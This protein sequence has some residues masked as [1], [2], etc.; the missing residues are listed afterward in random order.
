MAQSLRQRIRTIWVGSIELAV[1]TTKVQG[2][3]RLN[4]RSFDEL[5]EDAERVAA[6]PVKV[7]G[8]WSPGQNFKHLATTC[9]ASIDGYPMTFPWYMRA[10]GYLI[11]KPLLSSMQMPAGISIPSKEAASLI[12]APISSEEGLAELRA[13]ITRL[14]KEPRRARHP[15]LGAFTREQWDQLHLKHANLHLSF[16]VP[17]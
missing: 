3:R 4:F 1:K 9:H 6:G 8:N 16:L 13:A 2:R 5:L 7:L 12:P 14:Q 11:R 10:V 17:E 15:M